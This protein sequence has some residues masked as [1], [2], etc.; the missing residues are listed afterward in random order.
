[1]LGK[2]FASLSL[3]N[4]NCFDFVPQLTPLSFCIPQKLSDY[5][6][7]LETRLN[8][9]T[10]FMHSLQSSEAINSQF[11]EQSNDFITDDPVPNFIAPRQQ[12]GIYEIR[13]SKNQKRYYGRSENVSSRISQHKKGLRNG[14][15]E[16]KIMQNDFNLYG[17]NSFVFSV[18]EQDLSFTRSE[19]KAKEAELIQR[20]G[21]VC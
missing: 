19:L 11:S 14:K 9:G 2:I 12:P 4:H 6:I 3:S 15:H 21:K 10:S 16:R 8:R 18:I 5:K 7:K 20:F 13:C 1:M 17:E